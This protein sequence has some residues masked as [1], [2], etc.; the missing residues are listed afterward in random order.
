MGR[1]RWFFSL[2][3]VSLALSGCESIKGTGI[4]GLEG[5]TVFNRVSFRTEGDNRIEYTN[6]F[7]GGVLIPPGT[8]CAIK[9]ISP[10]KIKFIAK[11]H[12]YILTSWRIG[13]G[14]VNTRT[15]FYKFFAQNKE[16]VGLDG[17]SPEF[18]ESVLSGIAK[19]G[20]TKREVLLSLGY[21]AYLDRENPTAD[22]SRAGIVSSDDWYYLQPGKE[23]VSLKFKEGLLTEIVGL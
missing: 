2:I 12:S 3:L 11:G 18:R 13:Y 8:A 15:S 23:N 9:A 22:D 20:M 14:R 7:S 4:K 6:P 5:Q 16:A 1:K 21:P 19:V 17:I 10:K